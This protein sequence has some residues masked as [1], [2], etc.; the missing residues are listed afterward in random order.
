MFTHFN[1][2]KRSSFDRKVPPQLPVAESTSG[3]LLLQKH[4]KDAEVQIGKR[5]STVHKLLFNVHHI[6]RL[7]G[8]RSAVQQLYAPDPPSCPLAQRQD[9]SPCPEPHL[10]EVLGEP[11]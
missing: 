10:V 8:I 6:T 9:R 5:A 1:Y 2:I 3:G 11:H 7:P 4:C